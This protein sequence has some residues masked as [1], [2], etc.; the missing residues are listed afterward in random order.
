MTNRVWW[1]SGAVIVA[2]VVFGLGVILGVMIDDDDDGGGSRGDDAADERAG[3]DGRDDDDRDDDMRDDGA[4]DDDDRFDGRERGLFGPLVEEFLDGLAERFEGRFDEGE[5]PGR[6]RTFRLLP[7]G[8][9]LPEDFEL[10]D[11][12]EL[13]G[14]ARGLGECLVDGLGDLFGEGDGPLGDR[15]RSLWESCTA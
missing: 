9:E 2:G 14:G 5:G 4:E 1:I 6:D 15:A 11:R 7:D 3:G 13:P 10:P 12:F 8:F